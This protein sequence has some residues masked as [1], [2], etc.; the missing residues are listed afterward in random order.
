MSLRLLHQALVTPTTKERETTA[1]SADREIVTG[2]N[3]HWISSYIQKWGVRHLPSQFTPT[4]DNTPPSKNIPELKKYVL[5]STCTPPE[6]GNQFLMRTWNIL[7]NT[8]INFGDNK[9]TW[10]K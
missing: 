8:Q 9:T 10:L 3:Q 1:R 6:D 4:L 2:N 5:H 7:G